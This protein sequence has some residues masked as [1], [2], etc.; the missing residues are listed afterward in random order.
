MRVGHRVRERL[1]DENV[2]ASAKRLDGCRK[3]PL[4]GHNDESGVGLD[5][6]GSLCEAAESAVTGNLVR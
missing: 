1:L 5:V 6:A 2:Q 4:R 3:V